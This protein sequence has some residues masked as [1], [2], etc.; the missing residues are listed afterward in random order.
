[1]AKKVL[2]LGAGYAGIYAALHL[3]KKKKKKDDIEISIIDKNP[4]HTLLT[5]LH[6]VAGN[7]VDEESIR[8]PLKDIFRDTDVKIITDEI[9]D[10]ECKNN[11]LSSESTKYEYD[12][13]IM[14][15]GSSPAFYGIEGLE[16]Y[17]H[18]LWSFDDA[19]NLREHIKNCFIKASKEEDKAE[20]KRLLTFVVG[21]AGFTG[22]EMIG[23]LALW[24]KPLC[25]EYGFER[26]DV[27]L[28]IIDMMPRI[29]NSMHEKCSKK[30]HKYMEKKLG[31]E[32]LLETKMQKLTADA[33][34]TDKGEIETR[35]LIWTA[36]IRC[37]ETLDD[38]D[39]LEKTGGKKCL[40]VNKY[41]QTIYKN[42]YGVG[43]CIA[44]LGKNGKPYPAMVETAIQSG[45]GAAKNIL[46][47]V[48]GKEVE[49]VKIKLHGAMVC[50]GNYFAVSDMMGMR[51]PVWLSVIM[52]FLVN[53]HYLY[54]INGLRGPAKYLKDEV[55]HRKQDKRFLAQHYTKKMQAW[56]TF[57]MRL[58][59]G[60]M[61]LYEGIVKITQGWFKDPKLA[62]FL[63]GV[64]RRTYE[65]SADAMAAATGGG[66][67]QD[68]FFRLDLKIVDIMIGNAT[69][70][71]AGGA[72]ASKDMFAK[73]EILDFR[74]WSLMP[75]IINGLALSSPG[76]EMF[77]QIVIVVLEILVGLMLLGGAFTFF[78]GLGS[79]VL[80]VMFVTTTGIYDH[81]WWMVFASIV[82]MG[83]A[84]RAF[85]LDYWLIPYT[86]RVW[87]S[88]QKSGRL[89]LLFKKDKRK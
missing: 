33:L 86:T 67:R 72:E 61:W 81:S 87:E 24:V 45:T 41:C 63:G 44:L 3:N 83:G 37:S 43:D 40:R 79:L 62:E 42:A 64:Y 12:Y 57:P 25:R 54:E 84:G 13:L 76:G 71:L 1:M 85:G 60:Y 74:G 69:K 23:E 16:E 21:G 26:D 88:S 10:C 18:T 39:D 73:I 17:S 89:R 35:S 15:M 19:V 58:F 53:A 75:W 27:R 4:Y 31:I 66:L 49:E 56:W 29:L 20:Q 6:E 80:L 2:V 55:C 9:T 14:G 32:I 22:V 68:L 38:E 5:E 28:V 51:L 65:V 59:L 48:R 7:R 77:F 47:Q 30:S 82:V 52:K 8:I 11:Y 70:F 78:G 50:V 36:G 34:F 46:R